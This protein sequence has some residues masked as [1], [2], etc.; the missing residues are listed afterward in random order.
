MTIT[1]AEPRGGEARTDQNASIIVFDQTPWVQ[2][3]MPLFFGPPKFNLALVCG[4][5]A[6]C[7]AAMIESI[8]DY[9]KFPRFTEN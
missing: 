6:S 4:F 2:M 3:P 8:G 7:F 5:T 1:N 9:S